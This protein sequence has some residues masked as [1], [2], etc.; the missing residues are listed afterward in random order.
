MTVCSF[1]LSPHPHFRFVDSAVV[2]AV[3]ARKTF[4]VDVEVETIPGHREMSQEKIQTLNHSQ[5]RSLVVDGE[6]LK[7]PEE[8]QILHHLQPRSVDWLVDEIQTLNHSQPSS[9]DWLVGRGG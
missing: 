7:T 5:L 8:I 9:F 2:T 3:H 6:S 4:R 1:K